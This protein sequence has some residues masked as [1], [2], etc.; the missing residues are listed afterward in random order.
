M[1]N[2]VVAKKIDKLGW[3]YIQNKKILMARSYNKSTFYIPGGK[4]EAGESDRAALVREINEE[5]SVDLMHDSIILFG[6]FSGQAD[7]KAQGVVVNIR[8]FTADFSGELKANAE[9]EEIAWL[10]YADC[11]RCSVVSVQVL[12]ALKEMQLID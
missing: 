6:E 2:N 5:L 12:N 10:T 4:R 3:I 7:G 1:N 9:I 8:C 11:H